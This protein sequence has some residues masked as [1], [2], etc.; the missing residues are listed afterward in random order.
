MGDFRS[1]PCFRFLAEI[2]QTL[3]SANQY[4]KVLHLIV[5]RLVRMYKCQTCAIVLID[6]RTEFLHIDH[7]HGLSLTFCK[8][9][10][11][12]IASA[13]EQLL[14]TGKPLLI[15]DSSEQP[16]LAADI[17]LEN[18]FTSCLCVQIIVDQRSLGY[19]HMDST[20]KDAFK[21][22]DIAALEVFAD[23]AGLAIVKSKL[24]DENLHLERIDRETGLEKYAPFSEKLKAGLK[25]AQELNESLC[26]MILDIDNF[27]YIMNTFG[28]EASQ[29]LLREMATAMQSCLRSVDAAGRYG[30]DEFIVMVDRRGLNEGIEM[31]TQI[32]RAI[33]AREFTD[34]KIRSSVSIGIAAY[35]QNGLGLDD[36]LVTARNAIFQAQRRGRN[37]VFSYQR[38]WH[39]NKTV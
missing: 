15:G 12:R 8:A 11:S 33:E 37:N 36:V 31:A 17:R 26:V 25:R 10:R 18:P 38:E 28:Y 34:Q 6:P 23:V 29:K 27:K 39:T 14:W 30:F 5:D 4:E 16:D 3:K 32:R 9:F 21:S 13:A 2:L 35:P 1:D 24:F 22:A 20:E 7:C 19:I